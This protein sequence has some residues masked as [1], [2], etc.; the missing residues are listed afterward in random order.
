MSQDDRPLDLLIQFDGKRI[1]EVMT[2]YVE[3]VQLRLEEGTIM[4]SVEAQALNRKLLE[5]KRTVRDVERRLKELTEEMFVGIKFTGN[6]T[7]YTY[8]IQEGPPVGI[9]DFVAVYSPLTDQT[10]L[11]KVVR[12]GRG[13]W[14]G[15]TKIAHRVEWEQID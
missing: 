2:R 6:S 3:S 1:T 4:R 5:A 9:G 8:E 13:T 7:V 15:P 10:E 12:I 14:V 11:V